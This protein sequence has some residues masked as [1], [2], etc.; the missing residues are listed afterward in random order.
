MELVREYTNDV[1]RTLRIAD[2]IMKFWNA[3]MLVVVR[4]DN[5]KL[6]LHFGEPYG[7]STQMTDVPKIP[8]DEW[9]EHQV[10][11]NRASFRLV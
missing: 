8:D 1:E 5:G 7:Q 9:E 11:Q 3:G 2:K 10:Q 6:Q 4:G